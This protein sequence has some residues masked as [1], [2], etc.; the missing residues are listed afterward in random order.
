MKNEWQIFLTELDLLESRTLGDFCLG[1][2]NVYRLPQKG[3][4]ELTQ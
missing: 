4:E 2:V 1:S 3:D